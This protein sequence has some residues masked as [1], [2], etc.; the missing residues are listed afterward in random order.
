M[1]T[2][3]NEEGRTCNKCGEFRLWRYYHKDKTRN[4]GY[5][6]ICKKCKNP[7]WKEPKIEIIINNIGRTC[8]ICGEFKDWSNF[9]NQKKQKTGKNPACKK[10]CSRRDKKWRDDHEEELAQKRHEKYWEDI[11]NTRKKKRKQ[12]RADVINIRERNKVY[13]R[14]PVSYSF[15]KNEVLEQEDFPRKGENRY[16]E[17]K[18]AYCGKY[19]TPTKMQVQARVQTLRG[20]MG[21]ENRFYCSE[22]CKEACPVYRKQLYPDGFKPDYSTT[23]F[24]SFVKEEIF[25]RDKYKCQ[26]CGETH[27][28]HAH[29]MYP[30][31]IYHNLSKDVKNGITLCKECHIKVHSLPGCGFNEIA[32]CSQRIKK[33]LEEQGINLNEIPDWAV[34]KYM[35][36]ETLKGATP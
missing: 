6:E 16:L 13:S 19:F 26:I 20:Q 23:E 2:I 1:E 32:A 29:H 34:D 25:K 28:L 33:E 27:D 24:P 3:I 11:E 12:Y 35:N 36:K 31:A 18:C 5:A 10:C 4:T 7:N 9:S 8:S 14:Q 22:H 17:V 21:G 30:G 15:Y